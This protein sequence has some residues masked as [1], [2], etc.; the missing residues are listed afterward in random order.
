MKAKLVLEDGSEWDGDLFGAGKP[1]AGETVF[2]TGM[3]GYPESL[4]DPWYYGQILVLTYPLIGNYGV[5]ACG[6][7]SAAAP[8]ASHPAIRRDASGDSPGQEPERSGGAGGDPGA[9]ASNSL[10]PWGLP[11][12]PFQSGRVQVRGLVVAECSPRYSHWSAVEGLGEWLAREGVPGL[13]GVDTRALTRRLRDRGTM[14]GK[15]VLADQDIAFFDPGAENL[16]PRVS[17]GEPSVHGSGRRR[18]ALLDCGAK[19]GILRSLLCRGLTVVRLPWNHDLLAER[20]DG[21]VLSNGPGDP[22]QCREAVE[23]VRRLLA[24]SRLPVLGICLGS[25]ILALAAGAD[26]YK[27]KYGHRGQNQPCVRVGSRRCYITSQN[28]G[29]AV[30]ERTLPPGWEP[31]FFNANDGTNEGIRHRRAPPARRAVPPRGRAGPGGHAFSLRRVRGAAGSEHA[32]TL[33][34]SSSSARRRSRSARPGSSTTPAARRS[35][36]SRKR[37]CAPSS[38]I[39]TSPPSRPPSSWPTTST[40]SR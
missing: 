17:V 32:P 5:P 24:D 2:N 29:Y 34:R 16:A 14:K 13:S 33:P 38:S 36:P 19:L 25:Q 12:P 10:A 18:V 23:N 7:E 6:R 26:T 22:R 15:F 1:A 3:V 9:G 40:S 20:V 21:V 30:D 31:W 27:L 8:G 35:R 39:R 4:T 37:G 11:L 28:H